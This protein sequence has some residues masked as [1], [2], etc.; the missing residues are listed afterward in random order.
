[1]KKCG[2]RPLPSL[3]AVALLLLAVAF[4]VGA[5]GFDFNLSCGDNGSG[6]ETYTDPT[7]GYSFE[8]PDDWELQESD[9]AEVTSGSASES[10]VGVFDPDGAVVDDSYVDLAQISIYE[11]DVTVDESKIAA[12]KPEVEALLADLQ[13]QDPT[14]QVVEL[15]SDTEVAGLSG[16]KTTYTFLM[17]ETPATC[18]F[19]FLFTGNTQY[20][21]T[22]QAATENWEAEQT[23]FDAIL[24]SFKPGA[25]K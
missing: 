16:F 3:V 21:I 6:V 19:Y 1:M 7:Y 8:Y 14:W 9:T 23:A 15:L 4:A 5:C 20:Q 10:S 25:S 18:Q 13:A 12:I 24:A 2:G 22:L 11:L 17:N